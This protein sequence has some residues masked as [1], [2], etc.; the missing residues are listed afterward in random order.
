MTPLGVTAEEAA[1]SAPETSADALGAPAAARRAASR[2]CRQCS[3]VML[4]EPLDEARSRAKCP[5]CGAF[6]LVDQRGRCQL[7]EG[8]SR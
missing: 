7:L 8:A 2:H 5:G 6:E 1:A 4:V 3:S